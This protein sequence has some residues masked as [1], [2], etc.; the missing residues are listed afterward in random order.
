MRWY[1]A[2]LG[3][4]YETFVTEKGSDSINERQDVVHVVYQP[5]KRVSSKGTLVIFVAMKSFVLC[6]LTKKIAY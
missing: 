4:L 3:S 2:L 6:P 1:P 5:Q